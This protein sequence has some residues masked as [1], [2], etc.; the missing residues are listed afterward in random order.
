MDSLF[1]AAASNPAPQ[2]QYLFVD[3]AGDP[4]LFNGKGAPIVGSQGCSNFFIVGKLEVDDPVALSEALTKLRLELLIDPY[5][6][7]VESFHPDRR[8][9]AAQF[10]AK[11]DVAEVRYMVFRLL[12]AQG[13]ALRFHAVVCD[14]EKLL[15]Q[16]M[17]KRQEEARYRYRPD[18]IYD[19]LMRSLFG[20]LAR[21]ADHHELYV[22]KRG[23]RDRNQAIQEAI[24]HAERDFEGAYGFARA[25]VDNWKITITDPVKTVCL[26]AVD[27]F[28]WAVQRFYELREHTTTHAPIREDRFL[29]MLFP[30]IGQIHDRDFGPVRGTYWNANN[31]LTIEARFG[32]Q[33]KK[34]KKS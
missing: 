12:R 2:T 30:Q 32:E 20:K 29:N 24:A 25:G 21:F 28:L 16:E 11:D 13:N 23:N 22:A 14:K 34:K 27:Y 4:T 3:E 15:S 17:V 26:Q 7:G 6:A 9:T 19:G 18:D 1:S 8:K 5:F 31:P 10:H 33:A